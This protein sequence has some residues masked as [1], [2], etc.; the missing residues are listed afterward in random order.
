MMPF[1]F[2]C[3]SQLVN[4]LHPMPVLWYVLKAKP[5]AS[6]H[7]RSLV[8]PS[9]TFPACLIANFRPDCLHLLSTAVDQP[10][11][12][13]VHLVLH[14]REAALLLL[15]VFVRSDVEL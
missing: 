3:T 4:H 14:D 8:P 15:K 1:Y 6:L 7:H 12:G 11:F 5:L 13:S 9:C 2:W 10:V